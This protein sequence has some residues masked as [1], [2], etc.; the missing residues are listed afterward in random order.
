MAHSPSRARKENSLHQ[1]AQGNS[2][3]SGLFGKPGE[4]QR[5]TVD[6]YLL[7]VMQGFEGEGKRGLLASECDP[8]L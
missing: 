8:F 2:T 4:L 6:A 3:G 5:K 7:S 1:K